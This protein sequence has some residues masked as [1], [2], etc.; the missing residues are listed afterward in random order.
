MKKFI[1]ENIKPLIFMIIL[2]IV[3]NVELPYYIE[4][5]GGT[6]NLTE[7]IDE[8]Y[9]KKNGSLNMLYVTEY[10]GNIVTVLLSKIIKTWDLYEISNQ[11]VS[12]EDAK[13]IYI[14]NKVMLENSIQNATLVAYKEANKKIEIKETKNIVI[15]T[16]KDNGIEIGDEIIEVDNTPV[17]DITTIKKYLETKKENDI[18]KI[19]I[20]RNGKTKE[21]PITLDKTKVIG[22]A[23]ITNYE[24][25]TEDELNINFKSGEG[26]S[27]GGLVLA[28]GIYSEITG[29]DLLKGRNVA[30]TGTI[31]ALGN[32]G[33]IDGVKYK[34]AGAVKNKMDVILVSPYNYEEAKKVIKENNYKIELVKV[35]TF[36][37]AIE[38][39]TK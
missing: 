35:S 6:I 18:V 14:R 20:K 3:V 33:E 37:E 15:A 9:N 30:G 27:S 22:I 4:A 34:I 11:Q 17:I 1:K 16:T 10:K 13:D 19:K 21:I 24:Y 8:N 5:P 38:Y 23:M 26:G 36:K 7:R 29:I 39:L 32:V 12:D 2:I 31:D 28:L 25:E